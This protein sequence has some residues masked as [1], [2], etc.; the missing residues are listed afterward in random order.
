MAESF[1]TELTL[2]EVRLK[3]WNACVLN[4]SEI[5]AILTVVKLLLTRTVGSV[6]VKSRK[7][8]FGLKT[9]CVYPAHHIRCLFICP[10]FFTISTILLTNFCRL[11]QS[12]GCDNWNCPLSF[13]C[14]TGFLQPRQTNWNYVDFEQQ[15]EWNER[16]DVQNLSRLPQ[17]HLEDDCT[18]G[19]GPE[20]SQVS[21]PNW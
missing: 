4:V 5:P 3:C 2:L 1:A 12:G 16:E 15:Q 21:E 17:R 18:T 20:T 7:K 6:D 11:L 13:D 19:N 9:N 14:L 8:F 10:F